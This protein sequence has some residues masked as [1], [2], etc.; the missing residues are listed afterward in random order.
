MSVGPWQI[1]LI[2][3]IILLLFGK[4]KISSF[5]ADLGKGMKAFK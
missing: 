3:L 5:M 2:V 1:I 4:G